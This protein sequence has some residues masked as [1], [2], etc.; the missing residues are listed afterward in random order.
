M[1]NLPG[2]RRARAAIASATACADS[3]AG[4]IPSVRASVSA[5][6]KRFGI[7][8]RKYIRRDAGRAAR[9]APDRPAHNRVRRKPNASAPPGRRHP[10]TDSCARR[11]ERRA[12]RRKSAR[13]V[14]PD[15]SLR[16]PASTPISFTFSIAE[17]RV[18]HADG[19]AASADAGKNRI[20]QAAFALQNFGAR[21]LA[22]HAMKIAH[23]HRIRMRAQR[24]AEQVMRG[25]R[26]WSPSRASLR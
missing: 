21:L 18:E 11:A 16:P 2:S 3:S 12:I 19:V 24:R 8:A 23:H 13:R 17:E 4:I 20:G 26:R 9:R 25:L 22:D 1:N 10:A 15:R 5:A 7:V 14:R 6:A